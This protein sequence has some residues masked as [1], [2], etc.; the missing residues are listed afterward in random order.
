LQVIL[1]RLQTTEDDVT[2]AANALHNHLQQAAA[3][4]GIDPQK[5]G[6]KR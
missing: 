3:P 2:T 4:A 1:P 6:S 5:N